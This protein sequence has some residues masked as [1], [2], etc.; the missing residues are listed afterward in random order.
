MT[1]GP[2]EPGTRQTI[3]ASMIH[4]KNDVYKIENKN[5]GRDEKS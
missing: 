4:L 1:A 5:T 2:W 3:T